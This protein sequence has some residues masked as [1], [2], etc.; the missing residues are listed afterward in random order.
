MQ[1]LKSDI[2][3]HVKDLPPQIGGALCH[4]TLGCHLCDMAPSRTVAPISAMDHVCVCCKYPKVPFKNPELVGVAVFVSDKQTFHC[5]SAALQAAC[6]S[7]RRRP[8][9][10]LWT[11]RTAADGTCRCTRS[12]A[13]P[14]SA[15]PQVC[16][17]YS[18]G[19]RTPGHNCHMLMSLR[20]NA[21]AQISVL[22]SSS[23][24]VTM[25][26]AHKCTDPGGPPHNVTRHRTRRSVSAG[27]NPERD[28]VQAAVQQLFVEY[29]PC[30]HGM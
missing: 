18:G 29:L 11:G 3:T 19:C 9:Q 7:R 4:Q 27:E 15:T 2:Y 6:P 23:S 20:C 26:P 22:H 28:T 16:I 21:T 14:W 10:A 1:G 24:T 5:M 12:A 30:T 8:Q 17:L 25:P 13:P